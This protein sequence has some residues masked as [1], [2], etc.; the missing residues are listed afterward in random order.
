[1]ET[2]VI[3]SNLKGSEIKP[4]EVLRKY[5]DLVQ[6]HNIEI[7]R[8]R[9]LQE[10]KCP[11]CGSGKVSDSKMKLGLNY[12]TC[13]KCWSIY[14]SPRPQEIDL[15]GFLT[16]SKARGMWTKEI[17]EP[18]LNAR[19]A[20]LFEPASEWIQN[21]ALE[22]LGD[23]ALTIGEFQPV[24]CEILKYFRENR[25]FTFSL[26]D[27]LFHLENKSD[28]SKYTLPKNTGVLF[29]VLLHFDTLNRSADLTKTLQWTWE[30]LNPGGLGFAH[31]TLSTG[32]DTL[33]L[34]ANSPTVVPPEFLNLPSL[35]GFKSLLDAQGFEVLELSTP[36][37]LDLSNIADVME[38]ESEKVPRALKY[39][40][41]VRNNVELTNALQDF[42]QAFQLSSRARAVFRKRRT[43]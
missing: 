15:R 23:R 3:H 22:I 2:G 14:V 35:E 28:V 42:L 9:P 16:E 8:L 5:L 30:H 36:G 11:C 39:I 21:M 41:S 43:T 7:S 38:S 40:L 10:S 20:K 24:H 32:L 12:D 27:P 26:I 18:T 33:T 29:D 34:G 31:V 19:R 1:M 6:E 4:K 17:F 37:V 25:K 13:D